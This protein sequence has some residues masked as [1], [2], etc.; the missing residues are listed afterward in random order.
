MNCRHRAQGGFAAIAAIFLVVILAALGG[1]MLTF[2]NTQHL[3][4]ARDVQGSRAYWAARAGLEWAL[5][6]L[7][8]TP[9]LCTTPVA[10]PPTPIEGFTI[11]V[12]CTRTIYVDTGATSGVAP[13]TI[14]QMTVTA[15]TG[16]VGSIAYT[17]RSVTASVEQ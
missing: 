17:D 4:S 9:A 2:S 12:N 6:A 16:T 7:P 1:F 10:A 3:T 13:T 14:F 15:S 11:A 5:V 8:A